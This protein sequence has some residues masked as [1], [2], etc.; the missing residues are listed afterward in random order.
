MARF[1]KNEGVALLSSNMDRIFP[2]KGSAK[3]VLLVSRQLMETH[4]EYCF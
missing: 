3:V 4:A 2:L 1:S